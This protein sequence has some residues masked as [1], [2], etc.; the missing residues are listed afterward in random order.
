MDV[1]KFFKFAKNEFIYGGHLPAWGA[2]S[3]VLTS[4]FLLSIEIS[5]VLLAVAYL[6]FY[7]IYAYDKLR[8]LESDFLT[9]QDRTE[10]TKKV[11]R[12]LPLIIGLS[13][14]AVAILLI[15]S[16][17]FA[18]AILGFLLVISGL[19]Y[20]EYLKTLTRKIIGFKTFYVSFVWSMLP[21]LVI[22]FYDLSVDAS[23][24]VVFGF[25]FLRAIVNTVFF[26]IKDIESD[27]IHGLKTI[28]VVLGKKNSLLFIHIVNLI[29]FSPLVYGV[30]YKLLPSFSLSL[31]IFYF[32][33]FYYLRLAKNPNTNIQKLS[34]IMVDGESLFWPFV[35]LLFRNLIIL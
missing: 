8:D 15:N 14:G 31:L 17:H 21:V 33:S 32:Y 5:W 13:I 35:L 9:N 27:K 12:Y 3:L 24:L 18:V 19:L 22:L 25:I 7:I 23:F 26:D 16:N 10:H 20:T 34:Y 1:D 30:Y 6:I 4:I 28:P 29:S 11:I 2:V